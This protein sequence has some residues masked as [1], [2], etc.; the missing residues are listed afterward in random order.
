MA[1]GL[2]AMDRKYFDELGQYDAGMDIW[3][4][5]NLEISFRV[6]PAARWPRSR[7][8]NRRRVP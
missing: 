8:R 7:R 1:G 3:G 5:E 4:G 2:F 6:R